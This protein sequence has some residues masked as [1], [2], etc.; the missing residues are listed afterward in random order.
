[1]EADVSYHDNK[2]FL[3]PELA[4]IP[5]VIVTNPMLIYCHGLNLLCQNLMGV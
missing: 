1:M 4:S 5:V 2:L 3:G